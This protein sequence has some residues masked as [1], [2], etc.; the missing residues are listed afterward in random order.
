M[1]KTK[2]LTNWNTKLNDKTFKMKGQIKKLERKLIWIDDIALI[3]KCK[4]KIKE[5]TH[6]ILINEQNLSL[7]VFFFIN[8]H[9]AG[10]MQ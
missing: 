3:W 10:Y 4:D 7:K 2:Q 8:Q 5:L 6:K 9:E 1:N